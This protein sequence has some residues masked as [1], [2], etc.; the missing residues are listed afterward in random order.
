M[1]GF[2][3]NPVTCKTCGSERG[4]PKDELCHSC[5]I[6]NRPNLKKKYFWTP[7][8]DLALT[9]AYRFARDRAELTELLTYLQRSSGFPRFAI[10]ARAAEL[11]LAFQ[12]RR[13][14][15]T[16]EVETMRELVG[17]YSTKT[18]ALR[19]G[20]SYHSVK[21]KV[22]VMNL[23][24]RVREGYSLHDVQVLVGVNS[25]KVY[26]WICKGWLRLDD[27]RVSDTQMRRFLR[28]HPEEYILRRVDEAWFKD[29][30]FSKGSNGLIQEAVTNSGMND[31]LNQMQ[32]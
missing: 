4:A 21:R 9:R 3:N 15:S 2:P 29:I 31:S 11:G 30:V 23:S 22:V 6:K 25:R 26:S 5:R 10:V 18:V 12:V 1:R 27:G 13:H 19:L 24:S 16:T 28:R 7:E 8:H 32:A 14:W 17:T 20:R